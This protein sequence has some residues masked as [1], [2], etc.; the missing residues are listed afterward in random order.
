V[1]DS[2]PYQV[3]MTPTFHPWRRRLEFVSVVEA[4]IKPLLEQ[5]GFI[6]NKQRWG[7]VFRRGLFEVPRTDFERIARAMGAAV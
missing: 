5:L 1:I 6:G 2:E 3:E 4:P 7:F